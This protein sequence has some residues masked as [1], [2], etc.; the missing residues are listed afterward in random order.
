MD[1]IK[2]MHQIKDKG[3]K[4]AEESNKDK[5]EKRTMSDRR[6]KVSNSLEGWI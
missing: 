6:R 1:E 4:S 2:V 3:D 5:E